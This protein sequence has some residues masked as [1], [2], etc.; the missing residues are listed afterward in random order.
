M[1]PAEIDAIIAEDLA[2]IERASLATPQ[3]MLRTTYAVLRKAYLEHEP[4][5]TRGDVL[6]EAIEIDQNLHPEF[7][8][9]YDRE[10]FKQ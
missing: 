7:W 6:K 1:T 4:Q 3:Q 5:K 9:K 10:Y 8:P 2:H